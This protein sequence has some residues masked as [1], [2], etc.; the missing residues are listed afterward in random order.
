MNG[1]EEQL[2]QNANKVDKGSGYI[3]NVNKIMI[4]HFHISDN[5]SCLPPKQGAL[6]ETSANG[7]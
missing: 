2:K 5:T 4:C 7:G 6:C 1:D 3:C